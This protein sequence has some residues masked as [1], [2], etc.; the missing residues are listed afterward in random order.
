VNPE[1][2]EEALDRTW[3]H[4][5]RAVEAGTV[6]NASDDV[7]SIA[8]AIRRAG[9]EEAASGL[10]RWMSAHIQR[11][12]R[13]NVVATGLSWLGGGIRSV[14]QALISLVAEAT[15]E[16]LV[17]AYSLTSGSGR[18]MERVTRAASSGIRC[19]LII[20]RF[21][22]QRPEAR[23]SLEALASRH[24]TSVTVYD[25]QD[26]AAE[27]LHAKVLVVDRKAAV[28]GSANLTFHGMT[29]SHE[30]GLVVRGPT[31]ASVASAIDL[32]TGSSLARRVL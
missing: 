21:S 5:S 8:E 13:V 22:E 6:A 17:T 20:N 3:R 29:A 4:L 15:Q 24:P 1:D 7:P 14:E 16:I 32:L 10:G 12:D 23:A 25:F 26:K 28:I 9:P 27:G 31:A 19:V 30:L 2:L 11:T 18:V